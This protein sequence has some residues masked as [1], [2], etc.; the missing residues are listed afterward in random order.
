MGEV[1]H[2]EDDDEAAFDDWDE[3]DWSK[4]DDVA[5]QQAEIEAIEDP[6]ERKAAAKRWA[7]ELA[8]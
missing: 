4:V 6:V 3:V 8:G 5:R 2:L 1:E 7:A